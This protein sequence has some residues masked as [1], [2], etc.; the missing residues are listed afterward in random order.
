[1]TGD[2][3]PSEAASS[4][5][6]SADVLPALPLPELFSV[7]DWRLVLAADGWHVL[8]G[9]TA[10]RIT[11]DAAVRKLAENPE[12]GKYARAPVFQAT[13]EYIALLG[14][15]LADNAWISPIAGHPLQG[16]GLDPKLPAEQMASA[17]KSSRGSR[18]SLPTPRWLTRPK[19]AEK[20]PSRAPVARPTRRRAGVGESR[21][22]CVGARIPSLRAARVR[23][24]GGGRAWC[25][26]LR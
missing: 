12:V 14:K 2:L 24:R 15:E 23:A 21:G 19:G 16:S 6:Q 9:S 1:M 4:A 3:V 10:Q 7:V 20:R 8:D 18:G 22:E 11:V 5:M 25:R 13:R 17:G 26:P